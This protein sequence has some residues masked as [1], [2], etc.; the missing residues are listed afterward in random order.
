[1]GIRLVHSTLEAIGDIANAG[2]DAKLTRVGQIRCI[3]G[4]RIIESQG[5][6]N[7]V[8]IPLPRRKTNIVGQIAPK[9][10]SSGIDHFIDLLLPSVSLL[11]NA[12]VR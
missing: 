12:L 11:A 10:L 6:V 7:L 8:V 5:C 4:P 1:M 2:W 9:V 3:C